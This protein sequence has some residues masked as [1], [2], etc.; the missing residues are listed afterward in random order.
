MTTQS[1][2]ANMT[3]QSLEA[4]E[5]EANWVITKL[6]N[7]LLKCNHSI[8]KKEYYF[9]SATGYNRCATCG[10]KFNI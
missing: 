1:L 2:E 8:I 10:K 4:T 6:S 7:P 9:G 3:I 5:I